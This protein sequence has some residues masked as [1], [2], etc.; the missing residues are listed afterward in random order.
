MSQLKEKLLVELRKIDGVQDGPSP[1]SG[2]TALFYSGK[3]FAHFHDNNELDLRLTKKRIQA[4]GLSRLSGSIHHPTRSPNS[5]WIE[6][7]FKD[8][9][10]VKSLEKLVRIAVCE[11]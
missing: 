11:L 4:L 1:V 2:G 9:A 7:R 6:V 8:E 3:E 5:P 10:D